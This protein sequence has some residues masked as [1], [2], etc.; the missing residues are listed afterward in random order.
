[1]A[2]QK[3]TTGRK[4]VLG[5]VNYTIPR[6][7]VNLEIISVRI[8]HGGEMLL[9]THGISLEKP[10]VSGFIVELKAAIDPYEKWKG[11]PQK[12]Q[13]DLQAVSPGRVVSALREYHKIQCSMT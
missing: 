7:H 10:E 3:T 6:T 8:S 2:R 12:D 9:N 4:E 5:A 11:K 13:A 1:M